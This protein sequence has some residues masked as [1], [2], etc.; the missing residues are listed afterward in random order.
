[1]QLL[2]AHGPE[3]VQHQPPQP[4]KNW[5]NTARAAPGTCVGLRAARGARPPLRPA[6]GPAPRAGSGAAPRGARSNPA[7]CRAP[8]PARGAPRSARL[9]RALTSPHLGPTQPTTKEAPCWMRGAAHRDRQGD[10]PGGG[11]WP[12]PA[13]PLWG[14]RVAPA[15]DKGA[16]RG[17][18]GAGEMPGAEPAGTHLRSG[19]AALLVEQE[20]GGQQQPEAEPGPHGGAPGAAGTGGD[21]GGPRRGARGAAAGGS[22]RRAGARRLRT[23]PGAAARGGDLSA[24]PRAP[25]F[26]GAAP[27]PRRRAGGASKGRTLRRG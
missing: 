26:V 1:M 6:L 21:G 25:Q 24:A 12:C 7:P 5:G 4:P 27:S 8:Q 20:G 14:G 15:G 13:R 9:P 18:R 11:T 17:A 19:P 16:A 3:P 10:R 22:L 2:A 23:V